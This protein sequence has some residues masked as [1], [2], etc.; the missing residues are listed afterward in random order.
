MDLSVKLDLKV[1][2]IDFKSAYLNANI[3]FEIFLELPQ[4]FKQFD[5]RFYESKRMR[6]SWF[7]KMKFYFAIL[8]ICEYLDIN[9]KNKY[10]ILHLR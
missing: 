3:D 1:H 5:K 2:Q 9:S 6:G 4:G 8:E 7:S 10:E